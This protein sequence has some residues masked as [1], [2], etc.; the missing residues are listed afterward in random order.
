M[1]SS[2]RPAAARWLLE[3]PARW[4]RDPVIRV[5]IGLFALVKLLEITA[6]GPSTYPDTDTYR[7]PG[8]FLDFSL[9]SLGGR[10]V[11]PWGVTAWLALWPS[12]EAIVLAQTA[13]S[14][15]AWVVL[16]LTV[17]ATVRRPF[18]RRGL[19]LLLFLVGCS[20]QVASWQLAILSESV[21]ISTGVLAL[22]LLIRLVRRPSAGRAV[23]FSALALWFTMTRPNVFPV[24]LAWAV[25]LLIYGRRGRQLRLG[26]VVAAT[27]VACSLYSYVYNV[28]S[29]PAWR[30]SPV[31]GVSRMTVAYGY[32][33]SANGPVAPAVLRDLRKSDAPPCMI[34]VSPSDVSDHG[35]T[36]W[37]QRTARSCPGMDAWAT[38]H[39]SSWW[40]SWLVHHP[41]DTWTIV[42]TELPNSLSPPV[43]TGIAAA[44]PMSVSS[45]FFG[46]SALPQSAIPTRT[47]TTQPLLGW[48]AVAAG[49]AWL[50]R[51]RRRATAAGVEPV[52]VASIV[53]ALASAV[54][55]GLLIQTAPFEVGQESAGVTV[56]LTASCLV[57]VGLL[58]D[59]LLVARRE[60]T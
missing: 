47:F 56:V 49:L 10:S 29:D 45:A 22:A 28:R 33:I 20:A 19:A 41:A 13:L 46:S 43:W 2:R 48:L 59:E 57:L 11:R 21:S 51:R 15:V 27:L 6:S 17:T 60:A 58:L 55:S 23:A 12:D 50:A 52:L 35:T 54:S 9:T 5:M 37:V 25:A 44:V 34:P 18:V 4:S 1:G 32:P 42:R 8:S 24:L 16:A 30:A 39:W 7:V 53:G 3:Q 38:A 31:F 26:G 14:I 40:S 36:A